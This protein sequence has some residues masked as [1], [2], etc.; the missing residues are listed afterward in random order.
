MADGQVAVQAGQRPVAEH[1]RHQALVLDHGEQLAVA[2]GHAGRF[3]ATVLER[4][5]SQI[6]E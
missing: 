2:D 5:K 6:G 4:E 1:A 3:L